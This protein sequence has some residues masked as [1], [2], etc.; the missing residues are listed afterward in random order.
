M[1]PIQQ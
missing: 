1:T